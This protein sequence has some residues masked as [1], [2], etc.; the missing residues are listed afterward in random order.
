MRD[1]TNVMRIAEDGFVGFA[2][3][4]SFVISLRPRRVG[5]TMGVPQNLLRSREWRLDGTTIPRNA[6]AGGSRY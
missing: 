2:W 3:F 1:S 6:E 4:V 5:G